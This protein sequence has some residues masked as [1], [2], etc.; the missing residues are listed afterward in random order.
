MADFNQALQQARR[1]GNE[2][3]ELIKTHVLEPIRLLPFPK[4]DE[5]V[6]VILCRNEA[7]RLPACLEHYR[8]LGV[9][10]FAAIDNGSTD[11]TR[12]LLAAEGDTDVYTIAN[13]YPEARS[14]CYWRNR[15]YDYYGRNRWYLSIDADEL[16]VYEGMDEHGLID[17][18]SVL[19]KR[20]AKSLVAFLIDMYADRP[21]SELTYTAGDSM[22]ETCRFFDGDYVVRR[23]GS[24]PWITGGPRDRLT[25]GSADSSAHNL[26]KFPFFYWD[27]TAYRKNNHEFSSF[28][29]RPM[30]SGAL[31]H[32]KMLPDFETKVDQAIA[33]KN[34][35]MGAEFYHRYKLGIDDGRLASPFYERSRLYQGPE[36][37]IEQG[38]MTTIDWSLLAPSVMSR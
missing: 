8:K 2:Q 7:L 1:I 13:G 38:L 15:L 6:A 4:P 23:W 10:R 3:A 17:L 27:E 20:G 30:D 18:A 37:L 28:D 9:R 5:I 21:F 24:V 25:P 34:H 32:F 35:W 33:A 26:R 31:L 11:A 19:Q 29:D 16:L 12:A 14:G 36:S 22:I